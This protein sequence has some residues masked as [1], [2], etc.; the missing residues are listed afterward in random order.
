[1]QVMS[2]S[3]RFFELPNDEEEGQINAG[4]DADSDTYELT[5][6]EFSRLKPMGRPKSDSP[7]IPVSIRLDAD[8]V[9]AFKA[10]GNGWQT[11]INDALKEWLKDRDKSVSD[12]F[13]KPVRR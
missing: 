4:I 9:D 13:T 10:S 3:G 11:R 7:K 1:M 5:D 8:I 12:G 6:A 2:K